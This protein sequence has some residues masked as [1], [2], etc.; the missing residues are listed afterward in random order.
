MIELQ[1]RSSAET[2]ISGKEVTGG[3]GGIIESIE[4]EPFSVKVLVFSILYVKRLKLFGKFNNN[5]TT[6]Q[7]VWYW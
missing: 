3:G 4:I 6:L 2:I 5:L 7:L 1:G